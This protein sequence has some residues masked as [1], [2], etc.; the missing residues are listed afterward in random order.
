[1]PSPILT[2]SSNPMI[3]QPQVP[4]QG[5]SLEEQADELLGRAL[6]FGSDSGVYTEASLARKMRDERKRFESPSPTGID[7]AAALL[8]ERQ[9]DD[10]IE[11]AGLTAVQE[12]LYRLYV[13]GFS[14]RRM[15]VVLGI[16]RRTVQER[17]KTIKRRIREAYREGPYA[18][19]YE[20][21][22]SEVNRPAY[23]GQRQG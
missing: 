1:M 23:R 5:R 21:Y 4:A 6:L 16:G 7:D 11:G 13:G 17:L 2:R 20:V 14:V 8:V 9:I 15:S 3:P 22:L 19:W 12:I 18:G 10:L